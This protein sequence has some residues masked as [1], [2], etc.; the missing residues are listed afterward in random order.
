MFQLIRRVGK[1]NGL[2]ISVYGLMILFPIMVGSPYHFYPLFI[3]FAVS[4]SILFLMNHRIQQEPMIQRSA[5]YYYVFILL[6]LVTIW[7]TGLT[8]SVLFPHLFVLPVLYISNNF[9]RRG[10]MGIAILSVVIVWF[11]LA[12]DPLQLKRDQVIVASLV[13]LSLPIMIGYIVK[14]YI[15]QMKRLLQLSKKINRDGRQ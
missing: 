12:N 9:S 13:N 3:D 2:I 6:V 5:F 11:L 8:N 1:I 10:S 15:F 4:M 14:E 7:L